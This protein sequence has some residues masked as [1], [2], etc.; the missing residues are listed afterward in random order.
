[1]NSKKPTAD[2][3][4]AAIINLG[5]DDEDMYPTANIPFDVWVDY[6]ARAH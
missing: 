1:M 4:A 6:K 3:L 5:Y 2:Q